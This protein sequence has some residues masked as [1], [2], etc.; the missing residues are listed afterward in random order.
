MAKTKRDSFGLTTRQWRTHDLIVRNSEFG[1][2]TT[3]DEIIENYP[4]SKYKDGYV[5]NKDPHTHHP[6]VTVYNDIDELNVN[7]NIHTVT[8][9]NDDYEY[10]VAKDE[11]EVKDFCKP[12]YERQGKKKLWKQG[13]LMLKARRNGQMKL[14]FDDESQARDYWRTFIDEIKEDLVDELMKGDN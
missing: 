4:I 8:I 2:K 3:I 9:W 12:L 13:I 7:L 1:L 14:Q 5:K 10:W 11:K 6:C